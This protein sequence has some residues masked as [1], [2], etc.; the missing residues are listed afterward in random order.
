MR[1]IAVKFVPLLLT[2]NQEQWHVNVSCELREKANK[3]RTFICRIIMDD[4]SWIYGY[5]PKTK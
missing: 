4:E 2:N 1:R 5:N 3:D